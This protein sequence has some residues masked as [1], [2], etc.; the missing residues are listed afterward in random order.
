MFTTFSHKLAQV[1]WLYKTKKYTTN[2]CITD[3]LFS[4][5]KHNSTLKSICE[6]RENFQHNNIS[7]FMG[8]GCHNFLPKSPQ[9][10]LYLCAVMKSALHIVIFL[11]TII[12]KSFHLFENV[13]SRDPDSVRAWRINRI[14]NGLINLCKLRPGLITINTD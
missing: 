7:C 13:I 4:T 11:E 2:N 6:N 9:F 8:I 3:I 14:N 10:R 12:L 1:Q 5:G